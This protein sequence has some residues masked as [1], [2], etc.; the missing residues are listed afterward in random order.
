MNNEPLHVVMPA[1]AG[2]QRF[3]WIPAFAG[4]T[5]FHY[6]ILLSLREIRTTAFVDSGQNISGMTDL[7]KYS[8]STDSQTLT[9]FATK[10]IIQV[11]VLLLPFKAVHE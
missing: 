4:M 6:E 1:E 5:Y 11:F 3:F 10:Q 9:L 7:M 8:I 2:I